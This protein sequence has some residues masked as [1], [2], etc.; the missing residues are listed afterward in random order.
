MSSRDLTYLIAGLLLGWFGGV[1]LKYQVVGLRKWDIALHP[2]RLPCD[3][4]DE[5]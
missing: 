5:C 2:E 1:Y 4:P 3:I